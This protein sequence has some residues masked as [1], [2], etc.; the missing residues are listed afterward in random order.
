[1]MRRIAWSIMP[2][3]F[4]LTCLGCGS[5]PGGEGREPAVP[6]PEDELRFEVLY[7]QNCAGC[8]GADGKN[9]AAVALAN[10]EYQSL[11]DDASLIR[12]ISHGMSPTQMP[13]FAISSGGFLTDKQI[14]VLVR[15]MR[16]RWAPATSVAQSER[17][18]YAEIEAGDVTRGKASFQTF[19][20]SCHKASKQE[21]TS[22]DY[23]ALV[24]D[25][26]LRSIIVAGRPDIGQPDWRTDKPGSPMSN[27]NVSDIVSYL[28]SLRSRTPGQPYP[29]HREG[30]E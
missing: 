8:H 2:G 7:K 6:R 15:G 19:C 11:V 13:A 12:W 24:N 3:L 16:K 30:A 25:Q 5:H 17:P 9:G 23:L 22:P 27:Q 18:S 26:A 14:E 21:I 28:A 1:M 20:S 10:P 4:L 29:E